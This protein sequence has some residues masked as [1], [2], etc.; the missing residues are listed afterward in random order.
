MRLPRDLVEHFELA[1]AYEEDRWDPETSP[2]NW[3]ERGWLALG[4]ALAEE[5]DST[6][7]ETTFEREGPM[8][9]AWPSTLSYI[10]RE[11]G[12]W[13]GVTSIAAQKGAG[14][15]TLA[16][17]CAIEA[18]ASGKWQV[19][20]FLAEDDVH[21]LQARLHGYAKHHPGCEDALG[22]LHFFSVPM[23][24]SRES[25][26]MNITG[27]V[28]CCIDK[29]IL[30]VLDSINTIAS[31]TRGNYLRELHDLGLWAMISRRI[32]RGAV[33]WM[34]VSE[35]NQRNEIKGANLGFWS[36]QV[37]NMSRVKDNEG[38]VKMKL[39]KARRWNGTGDMGKFVRHYE[40]GR[41]LDPEEAQAQLQLI[42]GGAGQRVARG[43]DDVIF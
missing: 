34:L 32:S 23:G 15:T 12:G 27:A 22:W 26:L 2:Y 6:Y 28:D 9:P 7:I 4:M 3:A 18:A 40:A 25:M 10:E 29:P 8:P 39:A 35:T 16:T 19:V 11:C 38:L 21:G 1:H 41:F 14:K 31:M 37:L 20:Y 17:S 30:V 5:G 36:D 42:P 24:V 43:D 13:H 33:S